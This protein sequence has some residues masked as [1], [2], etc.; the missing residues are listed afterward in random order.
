[1]TEDN[2]LSQTPVFII[3]LRTI[4]F[5]NR[6]HIVLPRVLLYSRN[7]GGGDHS[8][9]VML[10]FSLALDELLASLRGVGGFFADAV[11]S[12][13]YCSFQCHC[14]STYS[15]S[16]IIDLQ[17]ADNAHPRPID[18]QRSP[19]W[20]RAAGLGAWHAVHPLDKLSQRAV[21]LSPS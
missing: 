6:R 2:G 20:T 1:M 12:L 16:S 18:V 13:G 7:F 14:R 3:N 4:F 8:T 9:Y 15:W 19:G 21:T 10:T 5:C 17:R 11:E